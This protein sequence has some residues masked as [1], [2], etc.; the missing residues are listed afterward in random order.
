MKINDFRG[1]LID[2]SAKKEALGGS[3]FVFADTQVVSVATNTSG[4]QK[5]FGIFK[6]FACYNVVSRM[7]SRGTG[8]CVY[9][10]P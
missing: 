2:V 7:R 5:Q 10:R 3:V 1:D 6:R 9:G 8:P 4:V